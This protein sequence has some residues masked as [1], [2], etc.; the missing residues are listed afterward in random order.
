MD[1]ERSGRWQTIAG[2]LNMSQ[3]RVPIE[4]AY[5]TRGTRPGCLRARMA[6]PS[7]ALADLG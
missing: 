6:T 3:E 2:G 1:L 4:G 7:A 5:G